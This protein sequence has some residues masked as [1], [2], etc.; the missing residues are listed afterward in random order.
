MTTTLSQDT[1]ITF[2]SEGNTWSIEGDVPAS[3]AAALNQ[4]TFDR[5]VIGE[6]VRDGDHSTAS[7][8]IW[9]SDVRYA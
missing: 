1:A 8:G 6:A 9:A 7:V 4:N 3:D 2:H 5:V